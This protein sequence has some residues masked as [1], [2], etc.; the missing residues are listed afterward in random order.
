MGKI[1]WCDKTINPIVGCSMKPESLINIDVEKFHWAY[2]CQD[3]NLPVESD[4]ED[5]CQRCGARYNPELTGEVC[6][7]CGSEDWDPHCSMCDGTA[8]V[9]LSDV[10]AEWDEYIEEDD[11]PALAEAIIEFVKKLRR[12]KCHSQKKKSKMR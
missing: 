4:A 1:E 11:A 6:P 5:S 9:Y 10:L 2:V 12:L 3:C 7:E 8:I